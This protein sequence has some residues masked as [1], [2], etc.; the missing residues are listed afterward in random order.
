MGIGN[1]GCP[2]C[3][4]QRAR[5]TR[6]IGIA[7]CAECNSRVCQKHVVWDGDRWIC[8]RCQRAKQKTKTVKGR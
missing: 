7:D 2:L 1:L 3:G 6:P 5:K 4:G 8:K